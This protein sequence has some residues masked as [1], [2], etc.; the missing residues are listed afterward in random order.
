MCPSSA[1]TALA[2]CIYRQPPP[3]R[4][5]HPVPRPG[6][7]LKEVFIGNSVT[8]RQSLPSS[9]G[10][11]LP[12]IAPSGMS[13]PDFTPIPTSPPLP[14]STSNRRLT[15]SASASSPLN[16]YADRNSHGPVTR[17][18]SSGSSS[19]EAAI[20]PR[21]R[22]S[23]SALS[24]NR[25]DSQL[26]AASFGEWSESACGR[27]RSLANRVLPL[28]QASSPE[29]SV[30]PLVRSPA[31]RPTRTGAAVKPRSTA[32]TASPRPTSRLT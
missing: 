12:S 29:P 26:D 6:A 32:A 9:G 3:A 24:H 23:S 17:A 25:R 14:S 7:R 16:P 15:P 8:P 4:Q 20:L 1:P 22:N 19:E 2:V 27:V 13:N 5:H 11:T 18:G 31:R 21:S 28:S 10:L 30:D